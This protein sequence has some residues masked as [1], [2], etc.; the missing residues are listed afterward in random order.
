MAAILTDPSPGGPDR[1]DACGVPFVCG[2]ESPSGCWCARLLAIPL[3]RA[4]ARLLDE[5]ATF[6]GA[7]IRRGA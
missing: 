2:L 6:E 7:R 5:M 3:L 1:C 4:A